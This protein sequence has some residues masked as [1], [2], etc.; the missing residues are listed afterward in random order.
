MV[1]DQVQVVNFMHCKNHFDRNL[2]MSMTVYALVFALRCKN[3]LNSC[4]I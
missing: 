2:L 3:F 1:L 4:I